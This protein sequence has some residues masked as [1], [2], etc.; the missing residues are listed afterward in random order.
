MVRLLEAAAT[1]R[2][3]IY[4]ALSYLIIAKEQRETT[5]SAEAARDLTSIGIDNDSINEF[6]TKNVKTPLTRE[7]LGSGSVVDG[8][9]KALTDFYANSGYEPVNIQPDHPAAMLA[10]V[11]RLIEKEAEEPKER[12][13]YWRLQHRFIKTYLIDALTCL[14]AKI[15]CRFTQATLEAIS[16]DLNLLLEALTCK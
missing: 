3:R 16:V 12:I 2:Y 15:P 6:L 4:A 5:Y 13:T 11:A 7:C 10:F 8:Y 14:R 9:L 1:G